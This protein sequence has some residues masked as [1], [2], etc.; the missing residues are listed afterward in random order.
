MQ[1]ES[2]SYRKTG[3]SGRCSRKKRNGHIE[4][5]ILIPLVN[6]PIQYT[7][8]FLKFEFRQIWSSCRYSFKTIVINISTVSYTWH[9]QSLP[10]HS[11]RSLSPSLG[12]VLTV[13]AIVHFSTSPATSLHLESTGKNLTYCSLYGAYLHH[14]S[15]F[16]DLWLRHNDRLTISR[17]MDAAW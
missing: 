11:R 4:T 16:E 9:L 12:K 7:L 15:T 6:L 1:R 8:W 14:L 5:K 10:Q 2:Y 13:Y 17:Y 3:R